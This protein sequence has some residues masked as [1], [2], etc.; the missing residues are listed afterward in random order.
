P[1]IRGMA[2]DAIGLLAHPK[3]S[4][5][6]RG[7]EAVPAIL[8]AM[9]DK[10]VGTRSA[11]IN[12][13][14]SIRPA[15]SV[16]FPALLEALDDRDVHVQGAAARAIRDYGLDAATLLPE[17]RK[18]FE[19]ATGER[20]LLLAGL[21]WSLTH[22]AEPVLPLLLERLKQ[23]NRRIVYGLFFDVSFIVD[24]LGGEALAEVGVEALPE[25]R[26][27]LDDPNEWVRL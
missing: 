25:V 10:D 23:S 2:A 18:R 20:R 4:P 16:A 27:L 14:S 21:L 1:F 9:H 11:A 19:A 8:K 3:D 15:P 7:R 13:L 24:Q 22:D 6:R 12:T 17:L 5:I 26:K